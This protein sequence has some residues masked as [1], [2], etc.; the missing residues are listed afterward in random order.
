VAGGQPI[1]VTDGH[2]PV[3][4]VAYITDTVADTVMLADQQEV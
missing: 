2:I 3:T 4:G 1:A